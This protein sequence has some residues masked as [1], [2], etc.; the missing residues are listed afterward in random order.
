MDDLSEE[1]VF[2]NVERLSASDDASVAGEPALADVDS[3]EEARA[4]RRAWLVRQW[5]EPRTGGRLGVFAALCAVSG[6]F[7]VACALLKG[8]AVGGLALAVVVA[9]PVVEEVGKAAGPLMV[10]EKKPWLFGS[11]SSLLLLGLA[12]GF[13][14]AQIENLLYFFVYI[15]QKD[16]TPGLMLWRLTACTALHMV[17]AMISCSGLARAWKRAAR[18]RDAFI[19]QP[20]VPYFLTAMAIHGVYNLCVVV[21]SAFT[22]Q[23]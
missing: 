17:C 4:A 3:A 19:L 22:G 6:I 13:V 8:T 9:A 18:E 20:A 2:H 16:L 23:G 15:K 12:S 21:Y 7:A 11:A 14:F 1:P 10:L 5:M